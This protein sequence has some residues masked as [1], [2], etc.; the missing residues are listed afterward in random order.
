VKAGE[1][2]EFLF[3]T[4]SPEQMSLYSFELKKNMRS[5]AYARENNMGRIFEEIK[6]L[7]VEVSIYGER[8]YKLVPASPLAPGEYAI[9]IAEEVYTFGVDQ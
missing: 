3:K 5:F 2:L 7:P 4:G 9:I 6:G 1:K 8:S